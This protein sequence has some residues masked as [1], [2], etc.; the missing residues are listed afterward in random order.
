MSEER[1]LNEVLADAWIE[2]VEEYLKRA[3]KIRKAW[4]E[5]PTEV[6]TEIELT[7]KKLEKLPWRPYREGHK[8]GWIFADIKGA[9]NL[10]ETLKASKKGRVTIGEYEY[11]ISHGENRDFISR[12]LRKGNDP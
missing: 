7:P 2:A 12:N 10:L 6:K 8:A 3:K 4:G 1:T 11:R 9:E 5:L